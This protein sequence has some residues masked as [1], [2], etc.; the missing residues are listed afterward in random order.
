MSWKRCIGVNVDVSLLLFL[1]VFV[2]L[3]LQFVASSKVRVVHFFEEA[4]IINQPN[5]QVALSFFANEITTIAISGF[6]FINYF[7]DAEES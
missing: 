3:L 6:H 5:Y 7:L 4:I 2:L 1:Q